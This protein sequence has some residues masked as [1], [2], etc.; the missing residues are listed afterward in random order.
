MIL[1]GHILFDQYEE[2]RLGAKKFGS[3]QS[4]I[5][6]FYA[7]KY[8][9]IGIQVNDLFNPDQLLTKVKRNIAKKK[10]TT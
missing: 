2:A 6:P 4:G 7:D 1:P 5:A 3:T 10:C 8:H 9:K